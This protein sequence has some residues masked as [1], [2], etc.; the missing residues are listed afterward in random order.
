MEAEVADVGM[1]LT[2]IAHSV[3]DLDEWMKPQF[4]S[5]GLINK[6]DG[7]Q[8]VPEP[9]GLVLIIAPW[10]YPVQLCF[11]PLVSAI[12]AGNACVVKP[13]EISSATSRVVAELVPKYLDTELYA[14]VEGAV[15]ETTELLKQTWDHICYTGNPQIA[16]VVMRAA[17][18]HLTPVTLELGGKSPAIIHDTA[19]LKNA[20]R[21][22]AWGKCM[23]AGQ[24]CIAPDYV[25][26]PRRL[27]DTFVAEFGAALKEF[28]PA[29]MKETKD[30]GRIV[31]DRHFQ[32]VEKLMQG[33][34]IA[35]GGSKD[36]SQRF[37]EPTLLV[38][39]KPE[40]A[41]MKEEIF[42][43]LLPIVDMDDI[44][45]AIRHVNAHE[46]PLALYLFSEDKKASQ[47]VIETT[48]SGG[49]C[50]NDTLM[51]STCM[52]LPFGGVGNS[53]MGTLH[54]KFGFDAFTHYK[55]CMVKSGGLEVVNGV[56]YAPYTPGKLNL[57]KKLLFKTPDFS[58]SS[59]RRAFILRAILVVLVALVA[60]FLY[61]GQIGFQ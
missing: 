7:C 38:D 39:V 37:I 23:N 25:M 57:M 30:F 41:I 45:S 18:E 31:N 60:R 36:A 2:E 35:Y 17:A 46:K 48:S 5:V 59:A 49:V 21:R 42:G 8:L 20:A 47:K 43:P 9:V 58:G 52:Q 13:S 14:V 61:T 11:G 27:R 6:M 40:D 24:T 50:V 54:G 44:D 15:E 22:I 51:H 32:R 56:R 53:G 28:Y 10:N 19:N 12:A 26:I 1:V 16:K 29:G 33:G 3:A 4:P 34:K 55:P